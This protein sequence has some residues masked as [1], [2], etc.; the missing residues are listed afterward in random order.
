MAR[1]LWTAAH[2]HAATSNFLF[3]SSYSGNVTT[4]DAAPLAYAVDDSAAIKLSAVSASSGCAGS[5]SFL[6]LNKDAATLFCVDEGLQSG[7]GALVSFKTTN[8]G[9]LEVL[10]RKESPK[11]PVFGA[12]FNGE[13]SLGVAHFAGAAVTA[14]DVSDPA[15]LRLLQTD[16]F[17]L[18][19]PGPDPAQD[20]PK[21]HQFL[22]DP[23]GEFGVIPDLGADKVHI[24]KLAGSANQTSLARLGEI[25]VKPGSGPR[26]AAFAVRDEQ[27]FMYLVTELASTIVGYKVSYQR[28]G[29]DFQELFTIGVHG[30][31]KPTPKQAF[32]SEIVISPD[33]MFAMVS[34]RNE[35]SLTMPNLDPKNGTEIKSDP[36]IN[37]SINWPTGELTAV[38]E[39]PCGGSFPRQFS[40]N[41]AGTLLAVAVQRAG[42]VTIIR[43]DPETGALGQRPVA[44]ADVGGEVTSVVFD[45]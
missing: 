1:I 36:I 6:T 43:R 40:L 12:L 37:F 42:R 28:G 17:K 45:E 14:W 38:Q 23:T 2:A 32:A 18:E 21:P 8:D 10:D 20:A 26:H 4:L 44:F 24:V 39:V 25:M 3:V 19:R 29:M 9:S 35:N 13:D 22:V 15:Q 31:G 5:P 27:T 16:K 11:G 7:G 30:D 33:Q 34:S 41:K